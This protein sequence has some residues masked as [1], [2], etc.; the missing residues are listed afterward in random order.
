MPP[1]V[2]LNHYPRPENQQN[3]TRGPI[4]LFHARTFER[5]ARFEHS[6][7]FKVNLLTSI[8]NEYEVSVQCRVTVATI[9]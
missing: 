9:K 5:N 2:P 7:L 1:S 6:D 8:L 3:R 4:L